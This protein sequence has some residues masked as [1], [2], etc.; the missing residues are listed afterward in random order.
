MDSRPIASM[1]AIAPAGQPR[2]ATPREGAPHEAAHDTHAAWPATPQPQTEHSVLAIETCTAHPTAGAGRDL[3]RSNIVRQLL[4]HTRD[5]GHA[6]ADW[7]PDELRVWLPDDTPPARLRHA[8]ACALIRA[9]MTRLPIDGLG[10]AVGLRQNVGDFGTLGLAMFSAPTFGDALRFGLRYA[11]LTGLMLDLAL[12]AP[13]TE[14]DCADGVAVCAD[15]R[16]EDTLVEDTVVETFLCEEFFVSCVNLCR[17]LLGPGFRPHRLDLR[18]PRPAYAD[19]LDA[20]FACPIHYAQPRN[21]VLIG[22]DDLRTAM[23][24]HHPDNLARTLELCRAQLAPTHDEAD[25]IVARV[26]QLLR[27][28]LALQP[29]LVDI[30]HA[31]HLGEQTLRRRLREARIGWRELHDRV[32]REAAD[33]LLATSAATVAEIGAAIGYSDAREFRRAFKRWTGAA[34]RSHRPAHR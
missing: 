2:D 16:V 9:A 7:C 3:I 34:P 32:R 29:R 31:M 19:R 22:A 11:P 18:A 28:R 15:L 17:G 8:Q 21:R 4:A 20:V 24:A 23:P 6:L 13:T 10:L 27:E 12:L 5:A 30:A 14:D 1:P 26:E 25:D 33:D